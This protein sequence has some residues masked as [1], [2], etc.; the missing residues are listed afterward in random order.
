MARRER[1]Q[2]EEARH[3]EE[4][5]ALEHHVDAVHRQ[6]ATNA[7]SKPKVRSKNI[8][9][10]TAASITKH[11]AITSTRYAQTCAT[12]QWGRCKV[13]GAQ[14]QLAGTPATAYSNDPAMIA[15]GVGLKSHE[16]PHQRA[17]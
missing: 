8:L 13:R 11:P 7:Q 3:D 6:T 15:T 14:K 2:E 10:T 1:L 16:V 4:G 12:A 9:C 17:E 5:T